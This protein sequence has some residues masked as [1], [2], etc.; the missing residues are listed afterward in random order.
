MKKKLNPVSMKKENKRMVLRYLMEKGKASR[1]QIANETGLAP[2]AIWRLIGELE[3][4]ELVEVR[5]I[6]TG[7]G[8]K[9]ALYA[10]KSSSISSVIYNMEVFETLVGIGFLDGSWRIVEKFDTPKDFEQFKELVIESFKA[11]RRNY[12]LRDVS[13]KQVYRLLVVLTFWFLKIF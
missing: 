5:D 4:E 1:V 7:K 9:S 10:P 12:T 3:E 13:K 8:R 2:S 11:I 6:S